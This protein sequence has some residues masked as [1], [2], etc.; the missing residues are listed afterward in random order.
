MDELDDL[1]KNAGLA[2]AHLLEFSEEQRL[3]KNFK[4]S[5]AGGDLD[6]E[7]DEDTGQFVVLVRGNEIWSGSA[8]DFGHKFQVTN[9]FGI[10]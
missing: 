9:R 5:Y 4:K 2:E 6:A 8:E 10:G 3:I 7:F 1:L